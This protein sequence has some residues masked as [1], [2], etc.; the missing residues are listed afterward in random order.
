MARGINSRRALTSFVRYVSEAKAAPS[1]AIFGDFRSLESHEDTP[2]PGEPHSFACLCRR[3]SRSADLSTR[4]GVRGA[5]AVGARK[6]QKSPLPSTSGRGDV[7]LAVPPVFRPSDRHSTPV[8]RAT[9]RA[10]CP[11]FPAFSPSLLRSEM[12]PHPTRGFFHRAKPSLH[13]PHCAR[14]LHHRIW[15][16]RRRRDTN[17][18]L[19]RLHYIT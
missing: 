5:G 16:Y 17:A 11:P 12:P 9:E 15:I 2:R 1:A 7:R 13:T 4:R 8:T 19:R 18:A 10:T 3:R 14:L 6:K